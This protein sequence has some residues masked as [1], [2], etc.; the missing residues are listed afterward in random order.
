MLTKTFGTTLGYQG[1]PIRYIP[2]M[3]RT[4]EDPRTGIN[5]AVAAV[6]RAEMAANDWTQQDLANASGVPQVTVQRYLKPDREIPVPKLYALALALGT[7]GA[8]VMRAATERLAK[9]ARKDDDPDA[10]L[11]GRMTAKQRAQALA[12]REASRGGSDNLA[13]RASREMS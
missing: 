6:L 10:E 7:T 3:A 9:S 8:E 4:K 13:E 11:L 2:D 5:G 1:Y 12:A